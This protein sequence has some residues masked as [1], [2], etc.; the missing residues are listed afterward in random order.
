[1]F[2]FHLCN[3]I[4][5]TIFFCMEFLAL[6]VFR[7]HLKVRLTPSLESPVFRN[8]RSKYRRSV[9]YPSIFKWKDVTVVNIYTVNPLLNLT[10][11]VV[12]NSDLDWR[13][14]ESDAIYK[15]M[16]ENGFA[17]PLGNSADISYLKGNF[18][19][20]LLRDVCSGVL[21]SDSLLHMLPYQI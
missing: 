11:M 2:I 14:T 21:V 9:V 8:S 12:T 18:K 3:F 16:A 10:L 19:P 6:S 7:N 15:R 4:Q 17:S 1:M 20:R 5:L 13:S